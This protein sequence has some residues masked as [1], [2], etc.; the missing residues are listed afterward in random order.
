MHVKNTQGPYG[1]TALFYQRFWHSLKEDLVGL[2]RDFFRT[3]SFDK[4]INE[5]NIFLI[6]KTEKPQRMTEFR[7]I[8]LCNVSYK[9]ISKILCLRLKNIYFG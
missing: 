6:L 9:F 1:L 8:S 3:R 4:R 7:P 2:V 5:T